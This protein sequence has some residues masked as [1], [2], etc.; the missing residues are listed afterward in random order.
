MDVVGYVALSLS[1][2]TVWPDPVLLKLEGVPVCR[3][4]RCVCTHVHAA[5]GKSSDMQLVDG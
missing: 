3:P 1:N 4:Q 5:Q 2:T